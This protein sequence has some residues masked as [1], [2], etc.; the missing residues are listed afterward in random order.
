GRLD[1]VPRHRGVRAPAPP[2]TADSR[3][4]VPALR[5][6]SRP[7]RAA[8]ALPRHPRADRPAR[9]ARAARPRLATGTG[10]GGSRG[11]VPVVLVPRPGARA[12]SGR[13]AAPAA[14]ERARRR[15]ARGRTGV[16]RVRAGLDDRGRRL[17][18][19]GL[20]PLLPLARVTLPGGGPARAARHALV[21]GS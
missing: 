3:T 4:P 16:P 5:R 19:S 11:G 2:A 12:G 6:A 14:A 10:R 9:R 17:P 13:R 7:A 20:R 18:W 1:C 21:G 15:L 8:R